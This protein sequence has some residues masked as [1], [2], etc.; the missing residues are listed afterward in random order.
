MQTRKTRQTVTGLTVNAKVNIRADYYRT[1]RAMCHS[2]FKSGSYYTYPHVMH[3]GDDSKHATPPARIHSLEPLEGMLSHIHYVKELADD[4]K[5]AEKK[6]RPSSAFKLYQRF[7]RFRRF[8]MLE[9]PLV[10]CEGKTDSIYLR[11]AIRSLA[12]SYPKLGTQNK[13][14]FDQKISFFNYDRP[15]SK[16]LNIKGGTGDLKFLIADYEKTM[17]N[18]VYKPTKYPVILLI[19]NDDGAKPIFSLLKKKFFISVN[20]R[21]AKPHYHLTE[22]LYLVKTPT[23]KGRDKTCIED[24]FDKSTLDTKVGGKAF[25]PDKKIDSDTEYGKLVFAERV[26]RPN[27]SKVNF[28]GF[29]S[30]LDRLVSAIED[31][32]PP[33][34]S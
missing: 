29:S 22:N 10:I 12:S 23:V 20:F 26:I 4:R 18:F 14:G 16:I 32:V 1:V 24:F 2:V 31:Y 19:D 11:S 8:V 25:N 7:L 21:S 30:I 15:T 13:S 5:K 9:R 34:S 28:S 6:E 33:V 27:T 3:G 17:A